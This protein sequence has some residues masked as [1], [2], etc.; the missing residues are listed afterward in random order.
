MNVQLPP[1]EEEAALLGALP[2]ER[3]FPGR[4]AAEID[5]LK[6]RGV[7]PAINSVALANGR[8]ALELDWPLS[9]GTV[10]ELL[11]IYPDSYP[12]IRPSVRLRTLPGGRLPSRHVA[13][14]GN[15]ICL[16]GRDARQWAPETLLAELLE[17]QLEAAL[18]G[19]GPEDPQ[20]EPAEVWWNGMGHPSSFC[21]IDTAWDLEDAKGGELVLRYRTVPLP[22]NARQPFV[23]K[24]LPG[25]QACVEEV[26]RRDGTVLHR[27]TGSLPR[28]LAAAREML[29]IPWVMVDGGLLPRP[30]PGEY[31]TRFLAERP[32]FLKGYSPRKITAHISALAFAMVSRG[33]VAHGEQ[34]VLWSIPLHLG[35]PS[36]FHDKRGKKNKKIT[37]QGTLKVYRA[38]RDD[39]GYRVPAL[40][41]L[42]DKRVVVV[43]AGA[44]GSPV[45]VDL[46]RNG[47]GRIDVVD[48]DEVEPGPTVRWALGTSVWGKAKTDGLHSFIAANYP[49]TEVC[50]HPHQIGLNPISGPG[51]DAVLRP[52]VEAADLVVDCSAS[53]SVTA[54]L[55][56]LARQAAVPLLTAHATPSVEGGEIVLHTCEGGCPTCLLHAKHD[57]AIGSPPGEGDGED[58]I[59]Q[60]AG[61]AERTFIGASYDLQE[62]SLQTVRTAVEALGGEVAKGSTVFTLSLADGDGNRIPPSWSR[63]SLPPHPQCN[64]RPNGA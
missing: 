48:H 24:R 50:G 16:I 1:D 56:D 51:D 33:E 54:Y 8:L 43:G 44:I 36:A 45:V 34:G 26:R 22:E 35:P 58:D 23:G 20:A 21:L 28:E 49:G 9:D 40:R 61:C 60:P 32:R 7:D 15:E 29:V 46:A 63:S 62:L 13:P 19:S 59:R 47:C 57:G 25:I 55:A 52:L 18:T 3:R 10:A 6:F 12:H 64:C 38:G 11:A 2:W 14:G 17:T 37:L 53:H 41:T 39:L 4:V 42:R 5:A 30:T 31:L 27:W